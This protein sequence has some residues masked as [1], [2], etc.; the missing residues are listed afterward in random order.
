LS[1]SASLF[2]FSRLLDTPLVEGVVPAGCVPAQGVYGSRDGLQLRTAGRRSQLVQEI[3]QVTDGAFLFA[4]DFSPT[5]E[6]LHRQVVNDS[7]WVHIQFRLNGGGQERLS[8]TEVIE[9]PA[10]S[11]VVIR[12]PQSSVVDRTTHATDSFRMACLLLNPRALTHLLDAP[13]SRLP[14]PTLWMA[15]ETQLELHAS[16]LPLT[17]NMRL[18]VNDVL[19]CA[20]RGAA[21]RA[22]M[23]AKSLELLSSVVHA[24]DKP[25]EQRNDA[26]VKL[27][28]MDVS[29]IAQARHFMLKELESSMT[30]AALARRVGLNRTKLALG[31]KEVYGVS[32]QAY[33]RD[34]RLS[35]ARELLQC[36]KVRVTD[37]ALS[38]GYS[39][40]SAFTRAFSR[41]FG[42]LPS[43]LR[44]C[45][46]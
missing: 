14:E 43:D 42:L 38:L 3:V 4:S 7:D 26:S 25:A 39:E 27:S 24:L 15:Q 8:Q 33:W 18:A 9:T 12:Y 11:C 40:A 45:K 29:K 28:P 16:L 13:A 20:Y 36:G 37:V 19:S 34:E 22:Y 2:D 35:R 6:S 23:R 31:F 5:G 41:K 17:S 32:V 1:T 46:K 21:R 44:P 10:R 30:L